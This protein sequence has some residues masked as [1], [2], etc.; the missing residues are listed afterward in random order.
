MKKRPIRALITM[1]AAVTFAVSANAGPVYQP[2]GANLTYGD[3][4]H[5]QR[6]LSAAGNPA[7]AA[8]D[9]ARVE[10][11][12]ERR[13]GMVVS[14]V[15]GLEYGN[16][17]E[18]FDAVDELSRAFKPSPPGTGGGPGQVPKPPDSGIDI[19]D[20]IDVLFPDLRMIIDAAAQ[21]LGTQLALD[22]LI[23]AE[24]YGK[25]FVSLDIPVV[26]GRELLGGSWTFGLNVSG[27]SKVFGLADAIEFD[28]VAALADL[29]VQFNL[30]PGDPLTTFDVVGDIDFIFDVVAGAVEI[31]LDSDSLLLTK[32]AQT[33]EVS[34]GYSRQALSTTRG[35]LFLGVEG[36]FYALELSSLGVRYGDIT[37]S[38]EL[39]DAIDNADFRRDDGFGIDIGAL[40]VGNNYQVGASLTNI[41]E[42]TFTYPGIDVSQI[43]NQSLIDAVRRGQTYTMERQL[44]LEGSWFTSNRRWTA[45]VGVDVNAVPDPVRD[46]FQWA[47]LSGGFQPNNRWLQSV[48]FGY[49]RNLAGTELSYASVGLTAFRF[50]N[51]DLASS[52]DTVSIN[53]TK[54]PQGLIMSF[55]FQVNF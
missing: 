40:W 12:G 6:L 8:A 47:T 36:K 49:R 28:P 29:Q 22:A 55:G 46:D 50:F 33:T 7:A 25:A 43:R 27:E 42:P 14:A 31:L 5:G 11:D 30:M 53:G 48:R 9:L 18:L 32:A 37:D 23:E 44:K 45:N 20:V 54:L 39:F 35:G 13:G 4:T 21:E 17:Q 38:E 19:G 51:F 10:G 2:P 1:A 3:V 15:A 26:L 24:A 52:L 41:N 34:A 16:V